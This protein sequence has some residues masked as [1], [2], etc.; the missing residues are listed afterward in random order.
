MTGVEA[1]NERSWATT[2]R[3]VTSTLGQTRRGR[4]AARGR[5][6][7]DGKTS[8][9]APRRDSD[10][11]VAEVKGNI[12]PDRGGITVFWSSTALQPPRQVSCGDSASNP[13]DCARDHNADR[14]N[15]AQPR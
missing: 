3:D 2:P 11:C 13:D 14:L 7:P 1:C 9:A 5:A 4:S 12:Q 15:L 6:S 10:G 8:P